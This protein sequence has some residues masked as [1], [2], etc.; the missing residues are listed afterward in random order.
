MKSIVLFFLSIVFCTAAL[1]AQSPAPEPD[2]TQVPVKQT[3]PE[4]KVQP[5]DANY[6]GSDD[7]RIMP[8]EIPPAV[9]RTLESSPEYTG[10]EKGTIYKNK[11]GN[12][13]TIEVTRGDTT[14]TYRFDKGGKPLI[15]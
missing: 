9:K 7:R 4:I 3:D 8:A 5:R 2:T 10:W 14:R 6:T 12:K 1:L 15:E 13:F 11:S